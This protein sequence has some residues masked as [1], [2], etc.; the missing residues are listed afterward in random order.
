MVLVLYKDR[1]LSKTSN[2]AIFVL[3]ILALEERI[4]EEQIMTADAGIAEVTKSRVAW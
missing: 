1:Q 2:G 3:K 4:C